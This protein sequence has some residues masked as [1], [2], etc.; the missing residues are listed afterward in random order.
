MIY[1]S[2]QITGNFIYAI[3]PEKTAE[4]QTVTQEYK[5]SRTP[6]VFNDTEQP[7]LVESK[8]ENTVADLLFGSNY[9]GTKATEK[10]FVYF[11]ALYQ[12]K[13]TS[14]NFTLY[15]KI[16]D[17]DALQNFIL[18]YPMRELSRYE[19][20]EPSKHLSTE[21]DVVINYIHSLM[22]DETTFWEAIDNYSLELMENEKD[23]PI[24]ISSYE[25]QITDLLYES[26]QK[27]LK[28]LSK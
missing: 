11:C 9:Q 24:G 19:V 6:I 13:E 3:F 17:I 25:R 15:Q 20:G 1:A 4:K 22:L 27:L 28:G 21:L 2:A 5:Q 10:G 23:I 7:V 16:L 12:C 26:K 8:I 18:G 14:E